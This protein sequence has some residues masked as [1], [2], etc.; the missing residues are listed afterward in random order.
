MAWILPTGLAD[1]F[2]VDAEKINPKEKERHSVGAHRPIRW[3]TFR[4][5]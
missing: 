1:V 3:K 4:R 5:L 2:V